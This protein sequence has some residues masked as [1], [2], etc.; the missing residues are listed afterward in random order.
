MWLC[1]P[2]SWQLLPLKPL[3][4]FQCSAVIAFCFCLYIDLVER[5]S[6]KMS[7]RPYV[8]IH[9]GYVHVR[10]HT[11]QDLLTS[12]TFIKWVG[13]LRY[14]YKKQIYVRLYL[15]YRTFNG[16]KFTSRLPFNCL[17]HFQAFLNTK[18]KNRSWQIQCN[19]IGCV[20]YLYFISQ[21]M[22]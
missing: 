16:S 19:C 12:Y 6:L 11:T 21:V 14:L 18:K 9:E 7:R 2:V 22:A 13:Y 10:F 20:L 3:Q 17:S 1:L 4:H 8:Y 5:W 15:V